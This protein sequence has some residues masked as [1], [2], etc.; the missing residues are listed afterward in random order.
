MGWL[1]FVVAAALVATP[2]ASLAQDA[3][4][5]GPNVYKK[6]LE[7]NRMRVLEGTFKPGA[8]LG[9]HSHPDHLLYVLTDGSLTFK[10]AGRTPF[11]MTF[12]SGEAFSLPAQARAAENDG[13]KDVRVLVVELKL[14]ATSARPAAR[15]KRTGKGA[16][17]A[18][19][20]RRR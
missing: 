6:V 13:D 16:G 17:K 3:L 14:P 8:K 5:V 20:K 2:V 11:E 15:G 7:N 10:P 18:Q 1:M 9:V 12:K 4:T 19:R